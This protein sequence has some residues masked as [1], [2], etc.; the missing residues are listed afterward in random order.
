MLFF[1]HVAASYARLVYLARFFSPLLPR[2]TENLPDLQR[3]SQHS[4]VQNGSG[5]IHA[6]HYNDAAVLIEG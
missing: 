2:V 5:C 3:F 6:T 1:P 4:H